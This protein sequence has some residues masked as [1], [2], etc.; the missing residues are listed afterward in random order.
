[1]N[2]KLV[3]PP[4]V[5]P[6]SLAE[7]KDHLRVDGTAEDA[8]I[9]A[10]VQAARESLDGAAGWLGR[11]LVTQTWDWLL[12]EFPAASDRALRVPLPP[13][14]SVASLKYLDL[15]GTE[16]TWS[17]ANYLVDAAAA[18]ARILPAYGLAWPTARRVANAVTVRFAAGYGGAGNLVPGPVRA[19]M[20]LLI[21]DLYRH[22][23]AKIDAA[24]AG[25]PAVMAL[26][27]PYRVWGF[28]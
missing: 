24:L 3:T 5:E 22:R 18:P 23:E 20:L 4:A 10:L 8:L 25:N 27:A 16:Q 7:A 14:Q 26:L 13:L 15:A 21:G 2:L 1:M 6:L 9:G 19:A 11:A 17:P 12:D 28:G